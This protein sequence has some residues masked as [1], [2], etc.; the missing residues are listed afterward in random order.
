MFRWKGNVRAV[1]PALPWD[2]PEGHLPRAAVPA[3]GGGLGGNGQRV[4]HEQSLA[5]A[6][7]SLQILEFG[8]PRLSIS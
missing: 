8:T 4:C 6:F 1:S 7:L 3:L 2:R 5:G